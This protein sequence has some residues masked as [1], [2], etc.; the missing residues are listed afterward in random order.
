MLFKII[1][2]MC[3]YAYDDNLVY[4]YLLVSAVSVLRHG[5]ELEEAAM[6]GPAN[7]FNG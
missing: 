7:N 6:L 4:T 2:N 3:C 5:W 1:K